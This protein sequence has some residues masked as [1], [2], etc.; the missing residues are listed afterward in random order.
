MHLNGFILYSVGRVLIQTDSPISRPR[1]RKGGYVCFLSKYFT[2][3]THT[4][5]LRMFRATKHTKPYK[6]TQ[7]HAPKNRITKGRNESLWLI[8]TQTQKA[9]RIIHKPSKG[10]GFPPS[11]CSFN[12]HLVGRTGCTGSTKEESPSVFMVE[13]ASPHAPPAPQRN[14]AKPDPLILG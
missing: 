8:E 5:T 10:L 9:A 2:L 7:I 14:S 1:E 13:H 6:S 12:C 11:G 3:H 4:Q